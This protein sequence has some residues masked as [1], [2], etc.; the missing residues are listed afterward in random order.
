MIIADLILS[1]LIKD[2]PKEIERFFVRAG[3]E[4]EFRVVGIE[5]LNERPSDKGFTATGI[6][7]EHDSSAIAFQGIQQPRVNLRGLRAPVEKGRI[8]RIIER[9]LVEPP[10]FPVH[11]GSQMFG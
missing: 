5:V 7:G 4:S 2:F 10:V 6:A 8:R 3:Y 11:A 9:A 1:Q